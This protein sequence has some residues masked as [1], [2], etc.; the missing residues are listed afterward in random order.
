MQLP[1]RLPRALDYI[2]LGIAASTGAIPYYQRKLEH[3]LQKL[4][5]AHGR[6]KLVTL[7]A[8]PLVQ[9]HGPGVAGQYFQ[10]NLA[11]STLSRNLIHQSQHALGN[12]L[13]AMA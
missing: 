3:F 12:A 9:T 13:A 5:A 4:G 10:R 6:V 7:K 8:H 11:S 2:K 1:L